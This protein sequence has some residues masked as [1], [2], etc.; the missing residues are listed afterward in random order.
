M[1]EQDI[2]NQQNAIAMG[3]TA[4]MTQENNMNTLLL[5]L[6]NV[7]NLLNK[8]EL[9]LQGKEET[10]TGEIKKVCEALCNKEGAAT[11]KRLMLS[12]VN[13]V[14]QMSNFEEEQI[15]VMT[16]ELGCDMVEILTFNKH[17]FEITNRK[18]ISSIINV[19]LTND[20]ACAMGSL[21]NGMRQMLKKTT[22]E[23]TINTQGNSMRGGKGGG[24][25]GLIK[26]IFGGKQ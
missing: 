15:R 24:A 23:T 9:E 10:E 20:F 4:Y 19:A 16:I 17:N 22:M 7:E 1:E 21:E 3:R 13:N 26:G 18:A 14:V 6:L 2:M 12:M 11:V 25:G 5:E 8:I